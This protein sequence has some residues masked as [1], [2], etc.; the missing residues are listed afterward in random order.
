MCVFIAQYAN[1]QMEGVH[2]GQH[3]L[4]VCKAQSNGQALQMT[5]PKEH[6]LPE[7]Q[8]PTFLGMLC[9]LG[10]PT[11]TLGCPSDCFC[12]GQSGRDL[13]PCGLFMFRSKK[14]Q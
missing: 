10:Y 13:V 14:I 2:L 3:I 6:S 5:T 11:F 7:K 12:L 8:G 9:S 1:E 4:A